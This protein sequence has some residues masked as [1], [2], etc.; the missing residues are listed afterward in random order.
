MASL[1][2]T[3]LWSES[4]ERMRRAQRFSAFGETVFTEITELANKHGAINLGQGFPSFEGPEW[5]KD[6]ARAAMYDGKNQYTRSWG[7]GE[8]VDAIAAKFTTQTGLA[9]DPMDNVTITSGCTEAIAASV[10]GLVNPGDEVVL[11]EPY[12]DS[13][14]AVVAMAGGI[15]RYVTLRAPDFRLD[16]DELASVCSDRTRLIIVNSPHNPTGRVFD[17]GELEG[18]AEICNR[19][20]IVALSDEVYEHMVF[21][22][23][24]HVSLASIDGMWE[25][26]L[27]L[28]SLGKT[29]AFTGWKIGW[30]IGPTDLT[31]AVRTAH[32]FITFTTAAPLQYGAAAALGAP[33]AYYEEL[34]DAYVERRTVLADGLAAV[35]FEVYRPQGTYFMLADHTAFGQPD[36]VSFVKWLISQVGVAAIPPS[37]FYAT[38]GEGRNLVRFA[39]CKDVALLEAAID[40]LGAL[41]A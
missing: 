17:R 37:A 7:V 12:Y 2:S 3:D 10:L 14:P 20:D 1:P 40:R 16:L 19:H 23:S 11:I 39:F 24:E 6:A 13:Y 41:D 28:S 36:D 29:F 35:G 4:G 32:Q 9:L 26:T 31:Y 25:R 21:D 18:I 15:A 22:E 5:V 8:L 33:D 38:E 27:T 30:A 34:H